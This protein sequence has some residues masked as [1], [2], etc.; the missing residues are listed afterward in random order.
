MRKK[1]QTKQN[2]LLPILADR[3]NADQTHFRNSGRMRIHTNATCKQI[4]GSEMLRADWT[5][6]RLFSSVLEALGL[7]KF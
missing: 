2:P 1:Q 7:A 3:L 4:G 6:E 5:D